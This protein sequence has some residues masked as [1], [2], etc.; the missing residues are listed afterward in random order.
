MGFEKLQILVDSLVP[1]IY[2]NLHKMSVFGFYLFC[3]ELHSGVPRS[4][5]EH[6]KAS[7]SD[8]ASWSVKKHQGTSGIAKEI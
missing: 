8:K 6:Q 7:G 5:K 3:R 4:T 2:K 1:T